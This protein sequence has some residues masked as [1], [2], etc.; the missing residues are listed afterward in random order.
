MTSNEINHVYQAGW[1]NVFLASWLKYPTPSRPDILSVDIINKE[2]NNEKGILTSTR[3]MII[4]NS[5]PSWVRW[6][7]NCPEHLYFVEE[8]I[9]NLKEQSFVLETK[10]L[11]LTNIFNLEEK[12]I[13]KPNALNTNWTNFKQLYTATVHSR[14]PRRLEVFMCQTAVDNASKGRKIMENTIDYVKREYDLAIDVVKKEYDEVLE[15][16]NRAL[17]ETLGISFKDE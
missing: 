10:N 7:I 14:L 13:Y 3:L 9:I 5:V 12:C 17:K 11:S 15:S 8:S 16:T 2:F 6:I 4:K 1:K